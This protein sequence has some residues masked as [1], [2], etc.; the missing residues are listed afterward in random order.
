MPPAAPVSPQPP[1]PPRRRLAPVPDDRAARRGA[2]VERLRARIEAGEVAPFDGMVWLAHLDADGRPR[3]F[4]RVADP[5]TDLDELYLLDVLSTLQAIGLPGV[6]VAIW[7]A[8]GQP[9]AVD[10]R[11]ARDLSRRL[12]AGVGECGSGSGRAGVGEGGG[13]GAGGGSGG[14]GGDG[15]RGGSGTVLD[16]VLVVSRTGHRA[17]RPSRR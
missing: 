15:D 7:R 5:V 12:G 16:A 8:S 14:G 1:P 4:S 2:V 3:L 6:T 9:A 13:G 17:V 11:L 10:R